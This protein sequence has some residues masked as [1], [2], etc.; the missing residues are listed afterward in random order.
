MKRFGLIIISDGKLASCME[1][2]VRDILGEIPQFAAVSLNVNDPWDVS[3]EKVG[4]A[5]EQ[6]DRGS[7]LLVLADI[8]GGTPFNV[9]ESLKKERHIELIGGMNIPMVIKAA[10]VADEMSLADAA[11]YLERYGRD[12]ITRGQPRRVSADHAG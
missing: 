3:V 8:G 2:M 11:V 7:G 9:A 1:N 6:V 5:A 10:Q 4:K 12:H